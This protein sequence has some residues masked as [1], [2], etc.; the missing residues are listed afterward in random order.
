MQNAVSLIFRM[1]FCNAE[2]IAVCSF[3]DRNVF[4]QACLLVL[5]RGP[6]RLNCE[7]DFPIA[8]PWLNSHCPWPEP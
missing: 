1:T 7:G 2:N 3:I 5:R 8:L 4:I 6:A